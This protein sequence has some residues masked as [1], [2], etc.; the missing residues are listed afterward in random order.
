MNRRSL[1]VLVAHPGTQY[2]PHLAAE[3]HRHGLLSRFAT[4][5][6][7]PGDGWVGAVERLVP[8]RLRQRWANRRISSV[9]AARIASFPELEWKARRRLWRGEPAERVLSDRNEAFQR[10]L[11]ARWLEEATHIIGFDT[12]SWLLARRAVGCGR[13]FILDQSIG[14]PVA[15]ERVY[16]ELRIR[17]PDWAETVP[18]KSDVHLS[19][20]ASEHELAGTIVAPS[21]FVRRT[22]VESGV[23]PGKIRIIP[24]G[25]DL[26]LFAPAKQAPSGPVIFLFAGSLSARKGVPCLLH[27]WERVRASGQAELWLAGAGRVPLEADRAAGVKWLGV[28][29][30]PELAATMRRAHVFVCPS[31]FEGLAQVQVEALAAGLPVIGTPSSGAEDVV[32]PGETG[33]VVETGAEEELAEAIRRMLDDAEDRRR[34]R[35]NCV[36]TRERLGWS[37]YGLR[38][39]EL[40]EEQVCVPETLAMRSAMLLPDVL[41]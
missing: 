27:A 34:M 1:Q 6:M 10:R 39:R 13:H 14:H 9:P 2:A 3:L 18:S 33:M 30:R 23:V 4:G 16:A 31:F 29:S 37:T 17:Y 15:K 20:E 28:L 32:V 38:W 22:L 24:F 25:T 11:P 35:E 5:F 8:P 21:Q 19:H 12:S 40:L 36:A 26:N 7:V 41:R